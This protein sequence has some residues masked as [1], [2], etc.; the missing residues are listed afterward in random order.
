MSDDTIANLLQR[1]REQR[2]QIA[3]LKR[4][5]DKLTAGHGVSAATDG[6]DSSVAYTEHRERAARRQ[7]QLSQSG[8]EIAPLPPVADPERREACARDFQRFCKTYFGNVFALPWS[9]DHLAV[10]RKI[11]RAIIE[12]GLF[13]QAMPRGSGKT[14]LAMAAAIWAVLYGH[15]RFVCVVAASSERAVALLQAIQVWLETND[16]LL[17]DFPES[18]YPIRR[19]E[20]I[21]NRQKGQ[22]YKGQPTRLVFTADKIVFATI[23]GSPASG[24]VITTAGMKGSELR[25]QLHVLPDG[26]AMRPDLAIIDDPQTRESAY[27]VSQCRQRESIITGDVLGMAG[28]GKNISAILCCT[29]IRPGD[30]ADTLLDQNRHP[31]WQ[32]ERTQLLYEFPSKMELWHKYWDLYSEGLR[33]GG[34]V[35]AAIDFYK[36]NQAEMDEGAVVAWPERKDTN[37]ISAVQHVMHLFFRDQAAFWAEYQNKPFLLDAGHDGRELT[38]DAISDKINNIPRGVVPS[39]VQSVTCFIDPHQSLL[40]WMVTAWTAECNGYIV[41]YGTWPPQ[42]HGYFTMH[43]ATNRLSTQYPGRTLEAQLYAGLTDLT[44]NLLAREWPGEISSHVFRIERC[45]IDANWGQCTDLI[46]EFCRRSPH[47]PILL[48]SHGR[49]I[50]A[51]SRPIHM[52]GQRPGEKIGLNWKLAISQQRHIRYIVFD[53]NFW[54][55]WVYSRLE[56][57]I[58]ERGCLSLPG[59]NR[60][61]HRML[62]DHI[63]AEYR[64]P[65]TSRDRT[66]DEWKPRPGNPDN[67]LFDCLVGCS[68]AASLMGINLIERPPKKKVAFSQLQRQRRG[69]EHGR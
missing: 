8:R 3:T 26:T 40:Y 38:A 5:L 6:A 53:A 18:V 44:A 11:E 10:I 51:S 57:P 45:L 19:L 43:D 31:E 23:P 48:P 29:V 34:D 50:G 20:R 63:V 56:T 9:K 42:P 61:T 47:A 30:L 33:N 15:R 67:H 13:A 59:S 14:S 39:G 37:E 22:L 49:Y 69:I 32:G 27:S 66:V 24:S 36:N 12:G 46:Y 35:S 58:G 41:D 25:G 4:L 52:Q 54:K 2:K 62:A 55:S 28:P 16:L 17:A 65:V 60:Q 21:N 7:R 1:Q 68:V 64:V